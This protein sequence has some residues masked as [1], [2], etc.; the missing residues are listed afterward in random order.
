MTDRVSA[1]VFVAAL[2]AAGAGAAYP[3][4]AA[5]VSRYTAT[6]VSEDADSFDTSDA[7]SYVYEDLSNDARGFFDEADDG[8][9]RTNRPP[10]EFAEPFGDYHHGA[11]VEKDDTV[12]MVTASVMNNPVFLAPVTL[13]SVLV[14]AGVVAVGYLPR[15]RGNETRSLS[16][17]AASIG[18]GYAA[19][20]SYHAGLHVYVL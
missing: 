16:F 17:V 20:V 19:V 10:N 8:A 1:L 11:Y 7:P 18:F 6:V 5:D 13:L 2:L 9:V 3:F 4:V 12:Y 14:A 15:R